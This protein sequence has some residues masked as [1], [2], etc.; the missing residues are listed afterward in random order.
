MK[1]KDLLYVV[2]GLTVFPSLVSVALY[3]TAG[4]VFGIIGFIVSLSVELAFLVSFVVHKLDLA[5]REE[6]KRDSI[7]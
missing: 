3:F 5:E 6:E 1:H 7:L 4:T 2:L